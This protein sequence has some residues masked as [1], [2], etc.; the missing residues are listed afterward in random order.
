MSSISHFPQRTKTTKLS[1]PPR[2]SARQLCGDRPIRSA[3]SV[4][5]SHCSLFAASQSPGDSEVTSVPTA[6]VRRLRE[7]AMSLCLVSANNNRVP[8]SRQQSS[9]NTLLAIDEFR[10]THDNGCGPTVPRGVVCAPLPPFPP[11]RQ[12]KAALDAVLTHL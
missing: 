8:D 11:A 9:E 12:T 1:S 10:G 5:R 3:V 2:Q 6:P 4:S 7:D